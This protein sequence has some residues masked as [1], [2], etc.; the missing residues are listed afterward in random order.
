MFNILLNRLTENISERLKNSIVENLLE[1]IDNE[2][3]LEL[4]G[5]WLVVSRIFAPLE[6]QKKIF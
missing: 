4:V 1:F 5:Q 3:H 2:D 6:P